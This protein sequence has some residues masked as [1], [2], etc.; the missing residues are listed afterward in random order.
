MF[1]AQMEG[2]T[3][4]DVVAGAIYQAVQ[5]G[6]TKLRYPVGADAEAIAAA[7]DRM[8]AAEWAEF[9]SEEDEA[10]FLAR[11]EKEFGADLYSPPS[12]HARSKASGKAGNAG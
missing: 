8:T 4:P 7:R 12:L 11:A 9:L 10:K 1:R 3:T 6:A 2:G 5:E